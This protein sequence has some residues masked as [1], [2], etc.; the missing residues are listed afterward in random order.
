MPEE[1]NRHQEGYEKT[2]LN[3]GAIAG[4]AGILFL[5]AAGALVITVAILRGY[6]STSAGGGTEQTGDPAYALSASDGGPGPQLEQEP[7]LGREVLMQAAFERLDAYGVVSETPLRLHI[8]VEK[9]IELIAA[10]RAPYKMFPPT[11]ATPPLAQGDA[12]APGEPGAE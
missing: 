8:P 7:R 12:A 9:A 3:P 4:F 1:S 5:L 11:A 6:E 10:G 2:D